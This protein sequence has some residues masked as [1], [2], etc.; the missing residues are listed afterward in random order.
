MPR[1]REGW[2]SAAAGAVEWLMPAE[3]LCCGRDV[4]TGGQPL[5]C[6]LCQARW[7]RPT[8]PHCSRCQQPSLAGIECRLCRDWPPELELVRSAV[9][10]DSAVRDL[11]HHFKYHGWHRLASQM[12]LRMMPMLSE[13]GAG[14]L[15]PI[16]TDHA[17]RRR[18]GYDHALRLAQAL[19]EV[20]GLRLDA[21]RLT[22]RRGSISQVGLSP[23]ARSANL[24]GVF[25]ARVARGRV[26]LVDDVFTTG[27][28]LVSATAALALAG[29]DEVRG[30]TFARAEPPLASV[31]HEVTTQFRN[32]G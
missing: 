7:R 19:A 17:R 15:V 18:R 11:V 10:L 32:E 13:T 6:Q 4:T 25:S 22:R 14:V 20:S 8:Q 21:D 31:I 12:A 28:T 29:A 26:I 3:C 24:V 2:I 23:Q 30:V 27:A 9:L 5:I 1:L 16:P